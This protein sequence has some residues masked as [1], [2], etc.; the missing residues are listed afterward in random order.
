MKKR[1][2]LFGLIMIWISLYMS[3]CMELMPKEKQTF[4]TRGKGVYQGFD[5]VPEDYTAE[6]AKRDGCV[7]YRDTKLVDG[8]EYWEQ[9]L[10]S[11]EKKEPAKVRIMYQFGRE[12]E[13]FLED[14]FYDGKNFRVI[15]SKDPEVHDY[16][17]K[18]LLDLEGRMDQ[19]VKPI[20]YVVLTNDK[21]L[22]F[23]N[24]WD[25]EHARTE[26]EKL[27]YKRIIYEIP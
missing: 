23:Q 22:S 16:E 15:L 21:D 20:R 9:F 7:V 24:V 2:I 4:Q 18:Y 25:S 6:Q 13:W 17:Y 5:D 14:L 19:A 12:K 1:R 27:N 11:A 3:G 10:Q 8:G 26:E